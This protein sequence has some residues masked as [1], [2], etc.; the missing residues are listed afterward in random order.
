MTKIMFGK[1]K[2]GVVFAI[3]GHSGAKHINNND[4][5]CCAA[6]MMCAV[7]EN[8]LRKIKPRNLKI[9]KAEASFIAHFERIGMKSVKACEVA[10]AIYGG[11]ELLKE[12]Y[13]SNISVSRGDFV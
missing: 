10:E 9:S 8:Y 1:D 5:C 4:L 3:S 13:P 12:I 2:L 6:S 7:L 11:F